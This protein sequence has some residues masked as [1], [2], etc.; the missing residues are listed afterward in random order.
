MV[1]ISDERYLELLQSE[2]KL[3]ALEACGVDNW[4]GYEYVYEYLTP[5]EELI[6]IVNR[7]KVE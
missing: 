2:D 6:N 3:S 4:S 5:E 1:Q 7:M